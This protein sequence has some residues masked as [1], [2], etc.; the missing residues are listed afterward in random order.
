MKQLV[1]IKGNKH[2]IS[3][4]LDEEAPFHELM[5]ILKEKLMESAAFFQDA[6]MALSFDGR[7]LTSEEETY[8]LG[9]IG[10]YSKIN[11]VCILDEDADSNERYRKAVETAVSEPQKNPVPITHKQTEGLSQHGTVNAEDII[12]STQKSSGQFYKGTL[13]SGQIVE[14][15]SSIVILGDVNPGARV[16]ASGNIII[17]GALKGSVFAGANGNEKAF[18]VALT[19]RP[20]QI[21]IAGVI[22]RSTDDPEQTFGEG[23]QIALVEQN[24]IYIDSITKDVLSDIN[25]NNC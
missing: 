24:N 10:E 13:R 19:M 21:R 1:L 15:E 20:M 7:K 3:I 22:A 4:R 12:E 6:K 18:V 8:V 2:G 25:L 9:L 17:L 11:I 16:I 14:S 5:E 23:P